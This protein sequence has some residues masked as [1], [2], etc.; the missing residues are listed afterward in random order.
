MADTSMFSEQ[1]P[2]EVVLPCPKVAED[3]SLNDQMFVIA[4]DWNILS[5]QYGYFNGQLL[6][7]RVA[8]G[9]FLQDIDSQ[10]EHISHVCN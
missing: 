8:F 1:A 2:T 3:I 7:D 5:V 10:K 9:D 4:R 6:G